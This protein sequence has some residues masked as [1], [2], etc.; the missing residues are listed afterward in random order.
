M[1]IN[2]I[3]CGC[4]LDRLDIYANRG[5]GVL[6][7]L[8]VLDVFRGLHSHGDTSFILEIR[9]I[10]IDMVGY[11][12]FFLPLVSPFALF[13]TCCELSPTLWS[14]RGAMLWALRGT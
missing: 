11:L 10:G 1:F 5:T 9:A 12:P 4:A 13:K 2:Y 14:L 7:M 3:S 6:E 8:D